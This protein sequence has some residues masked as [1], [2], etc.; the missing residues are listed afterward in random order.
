M[1]YAMT[2]F[3]VCSKHVHG[4]DMT[5]MHPFKMFLLSVTVS[6]V[7]DAELGCLKGALFCS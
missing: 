3:T 1:P 7:L 2:L 6:L 4:S 5:Q